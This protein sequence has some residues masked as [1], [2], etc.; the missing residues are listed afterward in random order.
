[1]NLRRLKVKSEPKK[2]ERPPCMEW[3]MKN[4]KVTSSHLMGDS[5]IHNCIN[6]LDTKVLNLTL[7]TQESPTNSPHVNREIDRS[8]KKWK[9]SIKILKQEMKWR[10]ENKKFLEN[11]KTI[12]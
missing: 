4:G 5:H 9:L 1:M 7:E 10:T 8:I 11:T 12:R 6:M 3:Q 2:T